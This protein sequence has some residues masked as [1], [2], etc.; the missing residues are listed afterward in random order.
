VLKEVAF[1]V[2][3]CVANGLLKKKKVD[4]KYMMNRLYDHEQNTV[5]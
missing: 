3:K 4:F 5:S 2:V 1:G